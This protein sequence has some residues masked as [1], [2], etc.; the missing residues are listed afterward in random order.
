MENPY[1]IYGA[2]QNA[3]KQKAAGAISRAGEISAAALALPP[4]PSIAGATMVTPSHSQYA[5]LLPL[6]NK[7]N[8]AHPALRIMCT[9]TQAVADSVNWVRA[10]NLPLALRS[11]GHC[12]EGFSQSEGVVIDIRKMGLVTVDAANQ[13]VVVS[14]GASLG[15]VYQKVSDA[16]FAFAAGSCP[17]VGIAG[18]TLGGGMG[19]LGRKFGLCC[20]NLL[21]V[22][23]VGADGVIR[24][25]DAVNEPDLFW[26]CR[27]GGGGS[28]GVVTQFTFKIHPVA[29]VRTFGLVWSFAN[30]NAGMNL[31]ASLFNAWQNWAP[32]APNEI[33]AIMKVQRSGSNLM[34][35]CIGQSTGTS[36]TLSQELTA[37]TGIV[38]AGSGPSITLRTFFGAVKAFGGSFD[39]Q[40]LFFEAKSDVVAA[41]LSTVGIK[42]LFSAIMAQPSAHVAA[43]C[44]AYG[45]TIANIPANQSAFPHRGAGT[46]AIQYY[47][48]WGASSTPLTTATRLA[49]I[50]NVYNAMRPHM[51]NAAYVNYCDLGLGANYATDYWGPN[52]AR[53]Q[54]I[55]AVSDPANLFQ[56][57]QSV[58]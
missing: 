28:F 48:S 41:P 49:E 4:L 37:L 24:I 7:R 34:L 1:Y 14:A 25:A 52:L 57:A 5:S 35:R 30:T 43:L 13:K 47:S 39:Y 45:G 22:R 8:N 21:A 46:Y 10:N 20:D 17:T 44:D 32:H 19:L 23:I 40:S 29:Q 31:A 55:K 33:T 16:G 6:H 15:K 38:S 54:Q 18:H 2:R 51:T 11:G 9:S 27:G 56:H 26:A 53:L 36:A 12:Y 42:A 50:G 3:A 58:P